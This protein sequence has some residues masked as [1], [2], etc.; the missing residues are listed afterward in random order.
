[1]LLTDYSGLCLRHLTAVLL[2]APTALAAQTAT[3][4]PSDDEFLV[5]PGHSSQ[6]RVGLDDAGRSI[7][8]WTTADEILA[9]LVDGADFMALPPVQLNTTSVGDQFRPEVAVQ[10]NGSFLAIWRSDEASDYQIRY[11]Y[12]D[13]ANVGPVIDTIA[14]PAD[15]LAND[16]G[17][18]GTAGSQ[19]LGVAPLDDGSFAVVWESY[20][21]H[22]A[23]SD[24]GSTS[25][26][27]QLIDNMGTVSKSNQLQ[28]NT[29]SGNWQ[30]TPAVAPM[31]G[32]GFFVVWESNG[33]AGTD[34]I[35]YSV[36]G[37]A[38]SSSGAPIG[39]E[40]QLNTTI[41]GHQYD[42][43]I[44][45]NKNG[46]LL[47]AF[48]SN[49]DSTVVRGRL[50]TPAGVPTGVDFEITTRQDID[51]YYPVVAAL[52]RDF[53]VIWQRTDGDTDIIGRVV[54]SDGGLPESTF[55]VNQHDDQSQQFPA[56]GGHNS[57]AQAAWIGTND[58][59]GGSISVVARGF[60]EC[61]FCDGFE[62]GDTTAWN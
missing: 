51:Q 60:H 47:V 15:Q 41:P 26:Q 11:R 59:G 49:E 23:D 31:D 29:T 43:R 1:M 39:A 58:L 32:G 42:P 2:L 57:R 12:F 24:N 4:E 46:D 7:F 35:G 38:Y 62:S 54:S 44:A 14:A 28:V 52:D 13:S 40:I 18:A 36:Q 27:L 9:Y 19:G 16:L 33:S 37:Q 10:P 56:V 50:L 61:L 17:E 45:R 3:V 21:G 55:Q 8:V 6:P 48:S 20:L 5:H 34:G 25:I 53:L 30:L 22:G